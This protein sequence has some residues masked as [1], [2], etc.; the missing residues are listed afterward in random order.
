M[1]KTRQ[2]SAVSAKEIAAARAARMRGLRLHLMF[3]LGA[4]MVLILVNMVVTPS[5]PWWLFALMAWM[6]LVA[7]H[8]AIAM[9]LFGQRR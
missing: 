2:H 8:A 7:I 6:P 3:G 1:E 4:L 9:E 5:Y